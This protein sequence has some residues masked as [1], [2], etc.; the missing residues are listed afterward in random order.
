[1][2][3]LRAIAVVIWTLNFLVISQIDAIRLWHGTTAMQIGAGWPGLVCFVVLGMLAT[4]WVAAIAA[5]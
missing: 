3:A 4:E 5:E 1:M 2:T